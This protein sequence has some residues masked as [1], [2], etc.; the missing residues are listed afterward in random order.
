MSSEIGDSLC[1][2]VVHTHLKQEERTSSN[3]QTLQQLE[4]L[5]P[6]LRV[7]K[8]N[9]FTGQLTQ[10]V[11][12]LFPGYIFARFKFN[13]FYHRIRFTRGVHS[14]VL[15]NN[16][17]TPVDDEIIELIRSRIGSDG[18]VKTTEEFKPGDAVVI[19]DGRFK[20]LCG[21]FERGMPDADRVRI[22][23]NTVSFQAHVVVNRS[24]VA[25]APQDQRSGG[26]YV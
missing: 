4:T 14:L 25:K 21:V 6:K 22:L 20:N 17:P 16:S 11:K 9:E 5:A 3:L 13:K 2:Y 26:L 15:F 7:D 12:P 24:L 19:K 8:H 18:F 1:W 10:V 23:L